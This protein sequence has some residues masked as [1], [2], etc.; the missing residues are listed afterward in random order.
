[1]DAEHQH[2]RAV[3]PSATRVRQHKWQP[4]GQ[5]LISRQEQLTAAFER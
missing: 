4:L 3:T 2:A 1:M 5:V